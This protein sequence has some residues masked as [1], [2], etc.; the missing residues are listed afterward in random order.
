MNRGKLICA[1]CAVLAVTG[2]S[3]TRSLRNGE[4]LL[5]KNTV[6]VDDASFNAS[7]LTSYIA[8][9]PNSYL[10][11][12]NPLLSVYNWGGSS[13][14]GFA[15]FLRSIGT[16]PVVY[17]AAKVEESVAGI[18]NHLRYIGYYGSKVESDVHV[19]GRKVYVD[20]SV[21]LGRRFEIASV[22]YDIPSY[23]TFEEDFSSDQQATLVRE[24]TVL[25]EET[26]EK[27]AD[28]CS[29]S[30][31][32]LGYYG[33]NKGFFAFE[34]DTL[35]SDGKARLKYSVLDYALG[36]D[37]ESARKHRKFTIGE[38]TFNYP[39]ELKI[40]PGVLENLNLLRPGQPYSEE[41]I[42][43]TYTRLTSIGML[44]GVNVNV[45]PVSEDKVDCNISLRASGLQGFKTNLEASVNST[46][47]IGISPQITYYHKNIF[48]GGEL[49][50]LGIKGNFQFRPNDQATSTE[51]SFISS[52]RFPRFI[53][54]PNRIFKGP[55]I[56][57]T[58]ISL[59]L[60]YQ[61]RP[62]Y[63][64][65]VI[66]AAF[67][68][69]GRFSERLFY[70][71]SP[72]RGN[73]SHVFD[74]DEAFF[75]QFIGNMFMIQL[76]TPSFDLGVSGMLYYTTDASALPTRPYHYARLSVDLAGNVLALLNPILPA[77]DYGERLIW[78]IPYDQY[79]RGELQLG[80]TFRFGRKDRQ[81]LA[82]RFLAGAAYAYG[83]SISPPLDKMFYCGG[84]SSMRGWQ[85]RTLG[86][87]YDTSLAEFFIIPTQMGEMKL[88]ANVEY[89][90]PIAWKFEGAAFVDAGNVWDFVY[91]SPD[92][93]DVF[94]LKNLPGSIAMNWG[95]GLRLNLDLILLRLDAG[96]RV[97]D[98]GRPEGERWV[99]PAG[100]FQRDGFA[101]HFGVGYPF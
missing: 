4:F 28:R 74:I 66:S 50:N 1:L 84:S 39:R 10:L 76:F 7:S 41:A 26:L 13:E 79:V 55:Y 64:R 16:A 61:N 77:N 47:L 60:N 94:S 19:K 51:V 29:R 27:E 101:I 23:G 31:R 54:L 21:K 72:I 93:T 58:D 3:T 78:G 56:P 44:N 5:R 43:T 63:R 86:P 33:F 49:L 45:T 35:A 85:A 14:S 80:K 87:G 24:G 46:G 68:Y 98:P 22:S 96:F 42:N 57:R 91:D 17:D 81:A 83:N 52:I 8:Q 92:D 59:S 9:K 82:L 25:S 71:F 88:E 62:E 30:L 48:H 18:E 99:G 12:L 15:N 6:E 11:G 97:H 70:Q 53:G 40:R 67:T 65:S 32:N 73:I 38:V 89:R 36:D 90:F 95:L 100:W 75:N 37:P 34:A 2:C 20:Y 69:N